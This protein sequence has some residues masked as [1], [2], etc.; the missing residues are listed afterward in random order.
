V[1][2]RYPALPV[3]CVGAVFYG[4]GL[5]SIALG[6]GFWSF[7]PGM[8]IMS[9][10]ELIMSPTTSTFTADCAPADSRGRYMSIFG[11]SWPIGAG[12]GPVI[13]GFLSEQVAPVAMWYGGLAF[14]LLSAVSFLLMSLRWRK[15]IIQ[16][17]FQPPEA[18]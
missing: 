10:G 4:L 7:L 12:V 1:T 2:K 16:P 13:A 6:N 17:D 11:L 15:P 5:G 9:T 8:I 14:G 3:L 18:I